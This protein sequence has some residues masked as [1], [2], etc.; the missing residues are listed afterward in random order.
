M[1]GTETGH[2]SAFVG[3][4]AEL[5]ATLFNELA[6]RQQWRNRDDVSG[7]AAVLSELASLGELA[8]WEPALRLLA[9]SRAAVLSADAA[10]RAPSEGSARAAVVALGAAA[11]GFFK[12]DHVDCAAELYAANVAPTASHFGPQS[13]EMAAMLGN[14]AMCHLNMGSHETALSLFGRVRDIQAAHEG[15][16]ARA[17]LATTLN[18]MGLCHEK[19]GAIEAAAELFDQCRAEREEVLGGS[20]AMHAEA[21]NN[22]AMCLRRLG[23]TA[24]AAELLEQS[25]GIELEAL[26]PDHPARVTTIQNLGLCRFDLGSVADAARWFQQ[27]MALLASNGGQGSAEYGRLAL[28]LAMALEAQGDPDRSLAVIQALLE[29]APAG[30]ATRATALASLAK[31]LQR[32]SSP[33]MA[34]PV[35]RDAIDALRVFTGAAGTDAGAAGADA[36]AVAGADAG[37]GGADGQAAALMLPQ[38]LAQAA[39][40]SMQLGLGREAAGFYREC[41]EAIKLARGSATGESVMVLS[42]SVNI[43]LRVGDVDAAVSA[44]TT[45]VSDAEAVFGR[46]HPNFARAASTLVR[47][48]VA[49]GTADEGCTA[50]AFHVMDVCQST[51]GAD[52]PDSRGAAQL[53]SDLMARMG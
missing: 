13:R 2:G 52:H 37:G 47:A 22:L 18:N 30:S 27:A 6:H 32:T 33:E 43:S 3:R 9:L 14:L 51:L 24:E 40:C 1:A 4:V 5:R 19:M 25:V 49:Q 38:A 17:L 34:L 20:S 28:K 39:A 8:Q 48:R 12:A 31:L 35:W 36:G 46:D 50:L 21:L 41:N 26:G 15:G 7:E 23:R 42:K 44:A 53:V 11:A 16:E 29:T 10:L 45:A